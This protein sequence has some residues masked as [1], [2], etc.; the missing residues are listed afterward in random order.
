M[1]LDDASTVLLNE[2]VAACGQPLEELSRRV[3]RRVTH[4]KT[5][6]HSFRLTFCSQCVYH[7]YRD[8]GCVCVSLRFAPKNKPGESK[9]TNP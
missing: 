8:G 3:T 2:Y 6:E 4:L 7:A 1:I 9:K 5:N